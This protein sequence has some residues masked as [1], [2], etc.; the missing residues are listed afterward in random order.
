MSVPQILISRATLDGPFG[1]MC[2]ICDTEAGTGCDCV[3]GEEATSQAIA[4]LRAAYQALDVDAAREAEPQSR[5]DLIALTVDDLVLNLMDD[6]RDDDEDLPHGA[7]E[8]AIEAG[9]VT[10]DE[11]VGTFRLGLEEWLES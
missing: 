2:P 3:S 11:I 5:R 4:T 10:V 7:I 8:E 6:G 1:A 9:E